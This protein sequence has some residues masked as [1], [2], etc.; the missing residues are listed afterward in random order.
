MES[1]KAASWGD[2]VEASLGLVPDR[3]ISL[4]S[5]SGTS[6]CCVREGWC[7]A[8]TAGH[9]LGALDVGPGTQR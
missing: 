3:S 2:V 6:V 9:Q 7:R 1:L 5:S 8:T 4:Q